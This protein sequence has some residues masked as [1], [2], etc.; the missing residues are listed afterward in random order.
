MEGK[1]MMTIPES[2]EAEVAAV[3]MDHVA[4]VVRVVRI[5]SVEYVSVKVARA[6]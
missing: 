6:S 2:V 4:V 3:R 5:D 1:D